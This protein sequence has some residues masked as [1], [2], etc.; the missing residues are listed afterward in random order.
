VRAVHLLLW[1]ALPYAAIAIFLAG[2][3]WR[4]RTDQYG[5]TSRSTQI[6]ESRWLKW[7]SPLF[8]FGALAAIGGHVLGMLVPESWTSAVGVSEDGYHLLSATAGTLAGVACGAG[9]VLLMWRR[10]ASPRVRVTTTRT[11]MLVYALLALVIGLGLTETIGKNVL[12]GG[13]DYRSTV[14][15]W[16]RSVVFLHPEPDAMVGAPILYQLHAVAAWLVLLVW[17]FSRLVHAWSIPLQYVGRPY[18][19]YR[20]RWAAAPRRR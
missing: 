15:V 19:L 17:P 5:W 8:H 20:R 6:L 10:V 16:F 2:H 14:G 7:G 13:Y 4:Y 18:I 3:V 1:V 12:G 9:L 11:D